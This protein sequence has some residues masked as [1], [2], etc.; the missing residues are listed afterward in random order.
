MVLAVLLIGGCPD[1]FDR[2][3]EL[4]EASHETADMQKVSGNVSVHSVFLKHGAGDENNQPHHHIMFIEVDSY[5][6]HELQQF[7][8]NL[9]V[10]CC[11]RS[12]DFT[13]RVLQRSFEVIAPPPNS[14]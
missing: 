1:P 8:F 12:Y 9:S 6:P 2:F 4:D 5:C 10:G 7:T 11:K 14:I 13:S 3:M